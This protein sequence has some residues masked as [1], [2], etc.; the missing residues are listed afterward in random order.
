MK[1]IP[2]A[3]FSSS[4]EPADLARSYELGTN[5]Y[6]VKPVDFPAFV[7]TLHS[8]KNFWINYNEPPPERISSKTVAPAVH[9]DHSQ[10]PLG[11]D[12]LDSRQRSTSD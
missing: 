5:A 6:V 4:R 7:E 3:V 8:I 2:V 10:V 12:Q 9:P 1:G 11:S